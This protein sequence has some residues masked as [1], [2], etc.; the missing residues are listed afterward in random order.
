MN[1]EVVLGMIGAGRIARVHAKGIRAH[2]PNA[3]IKRIS[4]VNLNKEMTD[5]AKSVGIEQITREADP[6][7]Q[8]K[9]IDA[10]LIC[11]STNTH[12]DYIQKAVKAEKHVFCEKPV[13]FDLAMIRK[14]LEI[15]EHS[16]VKFQ[17]GFN[18][19][20]DHNF[21]KM[22][23]MIADGQVGV[24][25]ILKISSRDPAPP[26]IEY[27]RVSGGIFLDQMIHDFDMARFLLGSEVVSVHAI[28]AVLI[29]PEIGREGDVDTAI[30]SL[31][32]ENGALGVIDNSRRAVYGYDQRAEVF[33]SKGC[34]RT[35]NDQ[36]TRVSLETENGVM[37][38]KPL[39]FF[40]ERYSDAYAEE[41]KAFVGAITNDKETKCGAND[42][43]MPVVI[44]LAA[45]KSLKESRT[46]LL[47]EFLYGLA[48]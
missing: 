11:S 15:V 35:E 43:I 21:A 26:P 2:I 33:G 16:G 46:V 23:R 41:L 5:W 14:T 47:R 25:H 40:L 30:V 1:K 6:I 24:P 38:D 36:P 32:F 37:A 28:G 22:Q 8:D 4:D 45:K 48:S 17:I 42:A 3:R 13:D 29:S 20:F 7:F 18:R 12:S 19:R 27:V 31:V 34:C 10:V 39:Y 9:E 44:G